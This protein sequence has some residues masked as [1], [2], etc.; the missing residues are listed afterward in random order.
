VAAFA[1][2]CQGW[3]VDGGF[4]RVGASLLVSRV[5][6]TGGTAMRAK[7]ALSLTTLLVALVIA[8][9]WSL[10][11]TSQFPSAL[12]NRVPENPSVTGTISVIRDAEFS[13]KVGKDKEAKTVRFLIDENTKVEGKLVEGAQVSVEYTTEKGENFAV[14]VVVTRP[15]G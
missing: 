13:V 12:W 8:G 2:T 10:K 9:A 3:T 11:L 5:E 4:G 1:A 6:L 7:S 14:H 15:R